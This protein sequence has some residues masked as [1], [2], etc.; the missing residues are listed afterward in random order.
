MCATT[1]P[2]VAASGS[3]RKMPA[4]ALV[5][6]ETQRSSSGAARAAGR[7]G[8]PLRDGDPGGCGRAGEQFGERQPEQGRA[9]A[10]DDVVV[11][12]R[13]EHVAGEHTA[14]RGAARRPYLHGGPVDRGH[15]R[16]E[17][18]AERAE[19]G[20]TCADVGQGCAQPGGVAHSSASGT[21]YRGAPAIP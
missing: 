4:L 19:H 5:A 9:A 2:V 18:A 11:V 13:P 7:C 12:E 8:E 16:R 17:R 6:G 3:A 14:R 21:A 15:D 20:A 10:E 1:P